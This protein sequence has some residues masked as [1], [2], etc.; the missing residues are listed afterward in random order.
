MA[1]EELFI[2][3]RELIMSPAPTCL[4]THMREAHT[5]TQRHTQCGSVRLCLCVF[6]CGSLF[7]QVHVTV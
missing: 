5:H 6:V 7:A 4:L 3:N 2:D 1:E